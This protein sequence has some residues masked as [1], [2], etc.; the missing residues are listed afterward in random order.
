MIIPQQ[1]KAYSAI[2]KSGNSTKNVSSDNNVS[3]NG[4]GERNGLA[5][6]FPFLLLLGGAIVGFKSCSADPEVNAQVQKF[7][8]E[9]AD[10]VAKYSPFGKIIEIKPRDKTQIQGISA[11]I[12]LKTNQL[13]IICPDGSFVTTDMPNLKPDFNPE[14]ACN[15]QINN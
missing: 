8:N 2:A 9:N 11:K 4:Q 6:I 12:D 7:N 15:G 10:F 3:F 5:Y 14:V 1:Y 13:E